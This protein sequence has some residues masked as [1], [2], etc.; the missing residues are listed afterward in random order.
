VGIFLDIG[1]PS[2]VNLDPGTKTS[3]LA[4]RFH[5]SLISDAIDKQ[6]MGWDGMGLDRKG[7]DSYP[8]D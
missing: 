7:G 1:E 5:G 2:T 3:K 6:W 8:V 4:A